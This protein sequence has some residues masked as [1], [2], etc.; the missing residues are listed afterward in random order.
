MRAIRKG[1]AA[2]RNSSRRSRTSD[3]RIDAR[4]GGGDPERI[5]L[6]AAELIDMQPDLV[7]ADG[8]ALSLL[9]LKRATSTIPIVFTL[10]FDPVGSGFVA[11]LARPGLLRTP[12]RS[13]IARWDMTVKRRRETT[14][15]KHSLEK[16][17]KGRV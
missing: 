6:Y 13:R 1:S 9:P 12:D 8:G 10:F 7:W 4:W 16:K 3:V 17:I 11:S 15:S 2:W 14:P 5:R